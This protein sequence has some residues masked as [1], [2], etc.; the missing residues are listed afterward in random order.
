MSAEISI[1]KTFCGSGTVWQVSDRDWCDVLEERHQV[2]G[3]GMLILHLCVIT[4]VISFHVCLDWVDSP[5]I[6]LCLDCWVEGLGVNRNNGKTQHKPKKILMFQTDYH[7][8]GD[9]NLH[10][11]GSAIS[12]S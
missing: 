5:F 9:S 7:C 8:F 2:A 1:V 6:S 12:N 4:N 11:S 10:K 3:C